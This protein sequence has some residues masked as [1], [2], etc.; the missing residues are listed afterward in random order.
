MLANHDSAFLIRMDAHK[1]H[2]TLISNEPSAQP[3]QPGP[4]TCT[5]RRLR[6]G[7]AA[8]RQGLCETRRDMHGERLH[9]LPTPLSAC[10]G[11]PGPLP[12]PGHLDLLTPK[13]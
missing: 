7:A 5:L 2:S 8:H 10:S 11:V 13:A 3:Q 12:S 6:R 9:T 1:T 4:Y